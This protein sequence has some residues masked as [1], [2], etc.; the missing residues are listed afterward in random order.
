MNK[1]DL[2]NIL[3]EKG[4]LTRTESKRAV[5]LLITAI[6]ETL[7]AGEKVSIAGFGSFSVGEKAERT[8]INPSTKELITIPAKKV[9]KFK[10]GAELSLQLD[11]SIT[12]HSNE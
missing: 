9:V 4:N 11:R 1:S 2:I 8:V 6:E 3:V 5:E 12:N 10:L 7:I